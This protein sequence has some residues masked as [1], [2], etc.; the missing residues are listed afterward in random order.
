VSFATIM[1]PLHVTS[2]VPNLRRMLF[3]FGSVALSHVDD[4]HRLG[5]GYSMS[6]WAEYGKPL[7]RRISPSAAS[8]RLIV[9]GS[10]RGFEQRGEIGPEL[11]GPTRDQ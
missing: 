3:G 7:D 4:L 10:G 8:R 2:N 1:M 11:M 6:R 9:L 5:P